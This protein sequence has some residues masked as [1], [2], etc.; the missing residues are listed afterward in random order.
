[1][2]RSSRLTKSGSGDAKRTAIKFYC[3][4]RFPMKS[5]RLRPSYF[6]ESKKRA[7]STDSA[8]STSMASIPHCPEAFRSKRLTAPGILLFTYTAGQWL[9]FKR[10]WRWNPGNNANS[11]FCASVICLPTMC[12][13]SLVPTSKQRRYNLVRS[14]VKNFQ[15]FKQHASEIMDRPSPL[16]R[17][18]CR[19]PTMHKNV[20]EFKHGVASN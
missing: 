8:E 14:C 5:L 9:P 7:V 12:Q 17:V 10:T 15:T 1:M 4:A 18:L 3:L 19:D 2:S 20:R 11:S 13:R 6:Q 16:A